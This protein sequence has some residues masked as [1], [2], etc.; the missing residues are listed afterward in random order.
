MIKPW[1]TYSYIVDIG[2]YP[3]TGKRR[4]KTKGRFPRKKDVEVALR[5]ILTELDENRFIEPSKEIFLAIWRIGLRYIKG[6]RFK[7]PNQLN[8][9]NYNIHLCIF[10]IF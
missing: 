5:K 7:H 6:N 2:I 9:L 8:S 3:I 10:S 1:N 4:R